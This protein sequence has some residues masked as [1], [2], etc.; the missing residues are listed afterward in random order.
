MKR[1]KWSLILSSAALLLPVAVGLIL[2]GRLPDTIATHFDFNNVPNGWS[3]K[4][5]VVFGIPGFLLVIH[6]LCLWATFRAGGERKGLPIGLLCW[7]V[8][9]I[10]LMTEVVVYAYALEISVDVGLAACLVMGAVFVALGNYLPKCRVNGVCGFRVRWTMSDPD[11]WARTHRVAG[12][13]M[14]V[15]GIGVLAGAFFAQLRMA[16][17][18]LLFVA[19]LV[20]L[21]YSWVIY[22][23]KKAAS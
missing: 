17:F 20:P 16:A 14:V 23:K 19:V 22:R 13:C 8:P 7:V 11:I 10:T 4:W 15:C 18:A 6:L 21:V 5:M 1:Y 12:I 9:V 3:P 2:W